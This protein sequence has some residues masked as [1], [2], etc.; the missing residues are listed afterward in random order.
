MERAM[1][2]GSLRDKIKN[3]DI[4]RRTR[5]TDLAQRVAKQ[6]WQWAEHIARRTVGRWGGKEWRP[7]TVKRNVG[8]SPIMVNRLH[9]TCGSRWKHA[10][11]DRGS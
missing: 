5:V 11:Q 4:R 7:H 2:E 3:E 6:K 8:Q 10:A 1:L 9:Q